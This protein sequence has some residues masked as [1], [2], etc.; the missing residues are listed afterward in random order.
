MFGFFIVNRQLASHLQFASSFCSFL[1]A[2]NSWTAVGTAV[3]PRWAS[4]LQAKKWSF[5][6][7]ISSAKKL[8]GLLTGSSE[9][10]LRC[11]KGL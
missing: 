7:F 5:S 3:L 11:A 6:S 4:I 9:C 10:R 2:G 1:F 8:Q